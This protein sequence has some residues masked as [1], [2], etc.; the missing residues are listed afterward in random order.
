M[1]VCIY[2]LYLGDWNL[3]TMRHGIE[4]AWR[5][6]GMRVE[7]ESAESPGLAGVRYCKIEEYTTGR[8]ADKGRI[9]CDPPGWPVSAKGQVPLDEAGH[10]ARKLNN[11]RWRWQPASDCRRHELRVEALTCVVIADGMVGDS[12]AEQQQHQIIRNLLHSSTGPFQLTTRGTR[13]RVDSLW[14][15]PEHELTAC[16]LTLAGETQERLRNP[17]TTFVLERH[18]LSPAE[19]DRAFAHV[20]GY[21]PLASEEPH[22]WV[23]ESIWKDELR[24]ILANPVEES[25]D[26]VA[27]E[28]TILLLSY[29]NMVSRVGVRNAKASLRQGKD[30]VSL[31]YAWSMDCNDILEPAD[32]NATW[33]S[34]PDA[35]AYNWHL[36]EPYNAAWLARIRSPT[37]EDALDMSYLD[38]WQLSL[39]RG[40]SHLLPPT[41]CLYWCYQGVVEE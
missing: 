9:E 36:M 35:T 30:M 39:Q 18:L 2:R 24:K 20:E 22:Q 37:R 21:L 16:Y 19:Y 31:V 6:V 33:R 32:H 5:G 28:S 23:S 27:E 41:E 12:L 17:I 25:G 38:V 11:T 1:G 14:L 8:V 3:E 29:K 40:D 10:I 15:K 4:E 13:P 26:G 34:Y 7:S